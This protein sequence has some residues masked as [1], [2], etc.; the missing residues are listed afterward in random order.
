MTIAQ[1]T[2]IV[3]ANNHAKALS[4]P[5]LRFVVE[6]PPAVGN[7]GGGYDPQL[8]AAIAEDMA[9]ALMEPPQQAKPRKASP[10]P[11]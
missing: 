3:A 2:F 7:V 4:M 11:A 9:A 10:S 6:P 8:V 1:E 5:G